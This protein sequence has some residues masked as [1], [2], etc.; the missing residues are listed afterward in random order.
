MNDDFAQPIQS[1]FFEKCS[2]EIGDDEIVV[3]SCMRNEGQ[4]LPY[5]L[6]YYRRLGATRFLLVDNDSDDGTREF[7]AEQPDV[8]YFWTNGSYR[9]SSAGRL[10]L[11]ELADTYATDR[12]VITADVDELLVFPG[13]E[14]LSLQDLC[15]YFDDNGHEGLFTV[16]LDM[17]SDR[18][19]SQTRYAQGEDFL[20]TCSYFETDTYT[21]APGA[22]PPF[23]SIFGGPRDRLFSSSVSTG[24]KPMMKK[25]PLVKWREGFSYIFSTHSHRFVQL[26]DVTGVLMHFKFFSTFQELAEIEAERGDRRQQLHYSNYRDS[27]ANDVCFYSKSSMR[28]RGPADYVRLGVMRASAGYAAFVAARRLAAGSETDG[29]EF[30]PDPIA[31][32]GAMTI[33]SVAAVWPIINNPAIGEYF[34]TKVTPAKDLRHALVQ[35]MA[36]HV[37][38][39]DVRGDHLLVRLAEPALHRWQRSKVG[40]SVYVGR[41]LAQNLLIDGSDDAFSVETGSLEPN[42]CRVDVDIA[43]AALLE[44]GVSSSVMVTAYLFDGEDLE[45]LEGA[46]QS[47]AAVSPD[48]TLIHSQAWFA[49]GGN[50]AFAESYRGVIDRLQSGRLHGWAY[51]A[52]RDTFDVPVCVYMNGRLAHFAWPSDRREGLDQLSRSGKARGRG[53]AVDLPLGYFKAAGEL[54]VDVEVRIAGTN[55]ILRRS[56]M[57]LQSDVTD[58][59]WNNDDRTWVTAEPPPPEPADTDSSE[60]PTKTID[61]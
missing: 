48:D 35:E 25:I 50:V 32:E 55:L 49:E 18:P 51:S 15:A 34:G 13:C 8:E 38:V 21:I 4:R 14:A 28:Y 42:L 16:M 45:R 46:A 19:L 6:D 17:Y 41:R 37:R 60:A 7:L 11:Q 52:D 1:E 3:V 40:M 61:A 23:L 12:W 43:G 30:L 9:G 2:I 56:P 59:T 29:T 44:G 54:T 47:I 39:I 22:N 36:R 20:D 26:S 5:F 57:V 27:V 24:R 31:A 33:R 58:A 53:F 10:W